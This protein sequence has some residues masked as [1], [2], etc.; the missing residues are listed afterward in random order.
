M[1]KQWI[2]AAYIQIIRLY[3][4]CGRLQPFCVHSSKLAVNLIK[5]KEYAKSKEL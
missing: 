2:T 1:L 5:E 3:A 4:T